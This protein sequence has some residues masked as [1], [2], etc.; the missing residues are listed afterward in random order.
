[1]TWN[2][3]IWVSSM[4]MYDKLE[5]FYVAFDA[6]GCLGLVNRGTFSFFGRFSIGA[7]QETCITSKHSP[8]AMEPW[9][10]RWSTAMGW[11]TDQRAWWEINALHRARG[12]CWR[13][14]FCCHVNANTRWK[15]A[16]CENS[17][18]MVGHFNRLLETFL[19]YNNTLV[20]KWANLMPFCSAL[21]GWS[22]RFDGSIKTKK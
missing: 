17:W 7:Q 13:E 15:S 6:S 21:W 18:K 20:N 3:C 2:F 22:S 8:F 10:R 1:M 12:E 11:K 5:R 14:S 4:S 9:P 19:H 16:G